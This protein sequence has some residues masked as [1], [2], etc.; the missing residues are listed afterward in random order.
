MDVATLSLKLCVDDAT[1]NQALVSRILYVWM[2]IL[3]LA[4][5]RNKKKRS[6]K[7]QETEK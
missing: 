1:S 3:D 7:C 5:E 2:Y 6:H 4:S